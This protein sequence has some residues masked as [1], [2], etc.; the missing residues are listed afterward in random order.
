MN[1][2]PNIGKLQQ[3][4]IAYRAW[5]LIY[6]L[7]G[8]M[9]AWFSVEANVI[10]MARPTSHKCLFDASMMDMFA[11]TLL[12]GSFGF[13]LG[14][15]DYKMAGLTFPALLLTLASAVCSIYVVAH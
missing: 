1:V 12:T 9:V 10:W 5:Q 7:S 4:R 13:W 3:S 11:V 8:S 6:V 2:S 15:K 14:S